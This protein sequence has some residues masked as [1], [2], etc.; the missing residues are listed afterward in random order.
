MIGPSEC[1]DFVF[2]AKIFEDWFDFSLFFFDFF[3]S[4]S[5]SICLPMASKAKEKE[6]IQQLKSAVQSHT[7]LLAG[8]QEMHTALLEQ[9]RR[10]QEDLIMKLEMQN[11]VSIQYIVMIA[12]CCMC[13]SADCLTDN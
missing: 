8:M 12:T 7:A 4:K 13:A 9:M 3:F 5:N 11:M 1:D 6:D 10:N 2:G